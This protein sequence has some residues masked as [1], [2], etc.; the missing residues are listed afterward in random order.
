M[1]TQLLGFD[2]RLLFRK[3][4]GL[5]ELPQ[6]LLDKGFSGDVLSHLS[7]WAKLQDGLANALKVY[8]CVT[9]DRYELLA[10]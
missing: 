8:L 5:S 2:L 10:K 9:S 6:S 7:I 4:K 1:L 3:M